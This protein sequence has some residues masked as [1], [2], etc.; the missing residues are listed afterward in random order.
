MA[1]S[2]Q[3]LGSQEQCILPRYAS[4]NGPLTIGA[5]GREAHRHEVGCEGGWAQ[6][7]GGFQ[8]VADS[9]PLITPLLA[10]CLDNTCSHATHMSNNS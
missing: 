1:P 2:A 7:K 10:A 5:S 4:W 9:S 6:V 3:E 8:V